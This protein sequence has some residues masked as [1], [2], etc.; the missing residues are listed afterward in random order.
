MFIRDFEGHS[1]DGEGSHQDSTGSDMGVTLDGLGGGLIMTYRPDITKPGNLH[2][3]RLQ[4]NLE[5]SNI[6]GDKNL[7]DY[8]V[9]VR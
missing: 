6:L 2:P 5:A 8:V 7:G 9:A 3:P 1:N 4:L